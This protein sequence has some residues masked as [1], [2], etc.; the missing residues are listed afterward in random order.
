VNHIAVVARGRAGSTKILDAAPRFGLSD[1]A[2]LYLGREP[3]AVTVP[4][5]STRATDSAEERTMPEEKE[6]SW[7][8]PEC[9]N[10]NHAEADDCAKC[11]RAYD[12]AEQEALIPAPEEKREEPDLRAQ[13]LQFLREIKPEILKGSDAAKRR[14][15]D[16]WMAIKKGKD[17][18]SALDGLRAH[19]KR[20][21]ADSVSDAQAFDF[22]DYLGRD[23]AEVTEEREQRVLR[24]RA[25]ALR[26]AVFDAR[27]GEQ[28]QEAI[29]ASFVAKAESA[30][31]EL[32]SRKY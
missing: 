18:R 20:Q 24:Q 16:A 3:S 17:P 19:G 12:D 22:S 28:Q 4:S 10:V 25:E 13:A 6:K 11:G 14:W 2:A 5:H 26:R 27:P 8:C 23:V 21:T 31:R 15:N 29:A 30:G 1:V 7:T 9:R 32:R